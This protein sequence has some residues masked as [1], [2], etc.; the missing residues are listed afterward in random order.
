MTPD[1]QPLNA[2]QKAYAA[3]NLWCRL[4][5]WDGERV[6]PIDPNPDPGR[7]TIRIEGRD[8]IDDVFLKP[9]NPDQNFGE[10]AYTSGPYDFIIRF[11][12]PETLSGKMILDAK[13]YFYVYDRRDVAENQYIDLYR[14]LSPWSETGATWNS[15]TGNYDDVV[16]VARILHPTEAGNWS[17]VYYPPADITD[18]VQRWVDGTDENH[19]LRLIN[20]GITTILFKASEYSYGS[21]LEITYDDIGGENDGDL[22]GDGTIDLLDV[23][24]CVNVILGTASDPNVIERADMDGDGNVNILDVTALINLI[25]VP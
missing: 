12:L 20:G 3:W 11:Q 5:G 1:T 18:Q 15:E 16:P 7:Q 24:L 25:L 9:G 14:I 22:N 13:A 19:G 6:D 23:M 8:A 10:N 21:Y 2:N 17:H 4:A